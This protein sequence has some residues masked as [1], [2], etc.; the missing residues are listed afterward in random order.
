M[1][2]VLMIPPPLPQDHAARQVAVRIPGPAT[3]L[4]YLDPRFAKYSLSSLFLF[5]IISS[6]ISFPKDA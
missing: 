2:N 1:H 3:A 6:A 5:D 4:A